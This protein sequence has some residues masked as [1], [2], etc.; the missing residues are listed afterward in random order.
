MTTNFNSLCGSGG[1][2]FAQVDEN[3]R[4][5]APNCRWRVLELALISLDISLYSF[6]NQN[7]LNSIDR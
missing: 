5:F 3:S 4:F 6:I 7:V 1:L 2:H